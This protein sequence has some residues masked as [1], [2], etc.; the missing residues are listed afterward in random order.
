MITQ[1]GSIDIDTST[2][3]KVASRI[4]WSITIKLASSVTLVSGMPIREKWLV[5]PRGC[6]AAYSGS[7]LVLVDGA[8]T[9]NFIRGPSESTIVLPLS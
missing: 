8:T 6:I 4:D 3:S 2:A 5:T 7:T 9:A 1:P